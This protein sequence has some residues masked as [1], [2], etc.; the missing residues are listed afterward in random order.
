MTMID[1]T[2]DRVNENSLLDS[3]LPD[4]V[5]HCLPDHLVS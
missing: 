5:P 2:I 1:I 3:V 4:M